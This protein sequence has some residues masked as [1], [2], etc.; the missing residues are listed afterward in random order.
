MYSPAAVRAMRANGT[1]VV[2]LGQVKPPDS[3]ASVVILHLQ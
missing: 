1:I 3:H 2:E